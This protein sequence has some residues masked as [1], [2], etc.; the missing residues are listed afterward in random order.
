[1]I[2]FNIFWKDLYVLLMKLE[3]L[4]Q[5]FMRLSPTL[6]FLSRGVRKV[7]CRTLRCHSEVDL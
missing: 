6:L 1:M 5:S 4:P 3:L 7:F 2:I